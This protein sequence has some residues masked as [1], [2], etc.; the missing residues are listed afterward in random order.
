MNIPC[1]IIDDEPLA[2]ELLSSY[3]GR[4]P[5]LQVT[6]KYTSAVEAVGRIKEDGTQLLFLDIQMPDL[7]G[8]ELSRIIFPAV[9]VVFTTAFSEYAIES[10][11]SQALDYLLKPVSFTDFMNAATKALRWFE[12]KKKAEL[13]Y[14]TSD[15]EKIYVRSEHKLVAV[16][17]EEILYVEALKDYVMIHT[18]NRKTPIYTISTMQAISQSLPAERF[19]R[20]HRSYII[21]L[22]KIS[23]LEGDTVVVGNKHIAVS[24][25]YRPVLLEYLNAKTIK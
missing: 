16:S 24:R 18:V 3:A 10:Y 2:L 23:L 11:K 5:F 6:G 22:D 8:L 21:A 1:A 9:K 15:S 14:G 4:V 20:V 13:A 25:P 19:M 17:L 7:N 12:M